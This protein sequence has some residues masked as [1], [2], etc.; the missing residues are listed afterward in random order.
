MVTFPLQ[1][2]P[3]APAHPEGMRA[4][5][6]SD[7]PLGFIHLNT[8]TWPSRPVEQCMQVK[9]SSAGMVI[10]AKPD[11]NQRPCSTRARP[12]KPRLTRLTV[13]FLSGKEQSSHT[14][15]LLRLAPMD[16]DIFGGPPVCQDR[17]ICVLHSPGSS[18]FDDLSNW[19]FEQ[20]RIGRS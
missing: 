2:C 15:T 14:R 12:N 6:G 18:S 3:R 17:D 19:G 4:L 7:L 20:L 9:T 13:L 8:L 1:S 11:R 5:S 16:F 10:G